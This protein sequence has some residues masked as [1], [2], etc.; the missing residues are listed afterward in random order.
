MSLTGQVNLRGSSRRFEVYH[1]SK[2]TPVALLYS[3][4]DSPNFSITRFP[5]R[6]VLRHGAILPFSDFWWFQV[7]ISNTSRTSCLAAS[8][9]DQISCIS[10]VNQSLVNLMVPCLKY[11]KVK[12]C[13][14]WMGHVWFIVSNET[15]QRI[16]SDSTSATGNIESCV[17]Q[18]GRENQNSANY[19]F[20]FFIW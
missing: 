12:V 6:Y 14:F 9:N 8:R 20:Q 11:L 17:S 3:S 16:F 13:K 1:P 5:W 4:T 19:K 18:V 10:S 7:N 15:S 2:L